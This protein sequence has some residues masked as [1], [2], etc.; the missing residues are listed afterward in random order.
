MAF[1][2]GVFLAGLQ[3]P[4]LGSL[5]HWPSGAETLVGVEGN[6]DHFILMASKSVE[7]FSRICVPQLGSSIEAAGYNLISKW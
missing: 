5:V 6:G 3:V 7:E 2:S 1:Q 4:Q